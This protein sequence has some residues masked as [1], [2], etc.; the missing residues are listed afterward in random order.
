MELRMKESYGEGVAP[1]TGPESCAADRKVRGEALT[2]VRTGQPLSGETIQSG[3]PTL[4]SEAEGHTGDG[5]LRES[6]PGP[7][8]GDPVHVRKLH[9]REPGDPSSTLPGLWVWTDREGHKPHAGHERLW[10]VG[11]LHS[12]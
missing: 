9:S 6:F 10:E 11:C 5:V 7:A 8:V 1:H 2:G 3:T 4:L 12:T